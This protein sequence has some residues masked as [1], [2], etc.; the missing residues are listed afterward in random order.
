MAT[1]AT[2]VDTATGQ[3]EAPKGVIYETTSRQGYPQRK[4]F[5]NT[6]EHYITN[7]NAV[8]A[9]TTVT[10]LVPGIYAGLENHEGL[11][12][13]P[14]H[15]L[16]IAF[17]ISQFYR[18]MQVNDAIK[19]NKMGFTIKK[20]TVLQENLTTRNA[21]TF[22]ENTF[23][24]RV[25][26]FMYVDGQHRFDNLVGQPGLTDSV[27]PGQFNPALANPQAAYPSFAAVCP[28]PIANGPT[29]FANACT[30]PCW[31][32]SQFAGSLQNCSIY[33]QNLGDGSP[34]T[35]HNVIPAH[36]FGEPMKG[37]KSF[38]WTN[39]QPTWERIT[40]YGYRISRNDD[41]SR[42][43]DTSN[44]IPMFSS[45]ERA[46]SMVYR[47]TILR[48]TT[49][50]SIA[51]T[52]NRNE[53]VYGADEFGA[54]AVT[55]ES[56]SPPYVYLKV[57]PIEGPTGPITIVVRLII[58][59]FLEVEVRQDSTTP[60]WVQCT[61]V[62]GANDNTSLIQHNLSFANP[63][64]HVGMGSLTEWDTQDAV[65]T[66]SPTAAKRPNSPTLNSRPEPVLIKRRRPAGP[67][68]DGQQGE[69]DADS[70]NEESRKRRF[71][72]TVDDESQSRIMDQDISNDIEP[73]YKHKGNFNCCFSLYFSVRMGQIFKFLF[74]LNR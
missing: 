21:T 60:A 38:T 51:I 74:S 63:R 12:N 2:A 32:S 61:P 29:M 23:N 25:S 15:N 64:D 36:E 1:V 8:P 71:S 66:K 62:N 13:V 44:G 40:G 39:P 6:F 59:Y 11:Y 34:W 37:H 67:K 7:A 41:F 54:N 73:T 19:I 30:A 14:Y 53:P 56:Y 70:R 46:L 27:S 49:D 65:R 31:A 17:T 4:R 69:S 24:S 58:E 35:M 52:A 72:L 9:V 28:T 10:N 48:Q 47:G 22:L 3:I 68:L 16:G 26:C 18:T 5:T 55:D 20:V 42:P 50:D 33:Y 45:R 57:E 43:T